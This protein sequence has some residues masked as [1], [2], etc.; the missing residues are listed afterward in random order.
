VAELRPFLI[1]CAER[2]MARAGNWDVIEWALDTGVWSWEDNFAIFDTLAEH[3][4]LSVLKRFRELGDFLER[5]ELHS[6]IAAAASHGQ[7]AVLEWLWDLAQYTPSD[8]CWPH[9]A[10][11]GKRFVVFALNHYCRA[12]SG[13]HVELVRWMKSVDPRPPHILVTNLYAAVSSGSLPMIEYSWEDMARHQPGE[14]AAQMASRM[15]RIYVERAAERGSLAA[16]QWLVAKGM[17]PGLSAVVSALQHGNQEVAEWLAATVGWEKVA[18]E[19]EAVGNESV[20][21]WASR[22]RE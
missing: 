19:A 8:Q 5:R 14:L 13:G 6:A 2:H 4:H 12:V 1:D 21:A 3:G 18:E 20:R 9:C 10:G 17:A 15:A 16:V 22:V 11:T 7:R